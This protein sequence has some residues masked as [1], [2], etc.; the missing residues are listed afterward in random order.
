M[1]KKS[2]FI[3]LVI[4]TSYAIFV[5][6]YSD[7]FTNISAHHW[8]ENVNKAESFIYDE[9]S[10]YSNI[11]LGSSLSNRLIIDSLPNC[12]NLSFGGQSIFE[13]LAILTRIDNLPKSV[14]IEMNIVL[15][16][17]N[18]DFIE[19]LF[20]ILYYPKKYLK[21]LRG[22]FQPIT[23]FGDIV[24]TRITKFIL[25]KII[26]LNVNNSKSNPNLFEKLLEIQVDRYNK[27]PKEKKME[28]NFNRLQTYVS[29]L[30]KKGVKIVFFEMPINY[31]LNNLPRA[32]IVRNAFFDKFPS[33]KYNFISIPSNE[34]YITSD[35][36][37]LKPDE[38]LKY[39][40]FFKNQ[41]DSIN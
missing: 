14:F 9:N 38:A 25:P 1:I 40:L 23:N 33:N 16:E 10:V 29:S 22:K 18:E 8:Q 24:N 7:N 37:H 17:E 6:I 20:S 13:G 11:I 32:Q 39:T 19:S 12:F 35:G 41:M 4:F 30:E 26:V 36:L 31:K 21:V 27:I 5:S 3:F 15:K 34:N 28:Q 2:L